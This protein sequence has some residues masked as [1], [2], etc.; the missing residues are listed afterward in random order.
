[1]CARIQAT[2]PLQAQAEDVLRLEEALP[3]SE[4]GCTS[5]SSRVAYTFSLR[6]FR[7]HGSSKVTVEKAKGVYGSLSWLEPSGVSSP[8]A[9]YCPFEAE[10]QVVGGP[11]CAGSQKR[12]ETFA[13]LNVEKL[14]ELERVDANVQDAR[15]ETAACKA[16]RRP[17]TGFCW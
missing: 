6:L 15:G 3:G 2:R 13:R 9:S 8:G 11:A 12:D 17:E 5:R 1:M 16:C 14:Q 7:V 4:R 10:A